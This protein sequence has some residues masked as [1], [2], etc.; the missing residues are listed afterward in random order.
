MK[1]VPLLLFL[2]SLCCCACQQEEASDGGEACSCPPIEEVGGREP[3]YAGQ[4]GAL[5]A[6][7]FASLEELKKVVGIEYESSLVRLVHCSN[8]L[9]VESVLEEGV[10]E[11]DIRNAQ[12]GG[13]WEKAQVGYGAPYAVA[14]RKDLG[15]I[16]IL[17]RRRAKFFGEG[18]VAFY[19]LAETAL[20]N[21]NTPDLAFR[22]PADTSE[23]GYINSFNHIT[24]QAFITS[25][26]SEE[27]ADFVADVHER[28]N[29]PELVSGEFT[30]EQLSD[31]E[32]NPTD[33]YVDMINNEWGQELGKRLRKQFGI[34]AETHWTPR[35]LADY[36]NELQAYYSWA[37]QIGFRSVQPQDEV[38]V[39]FADKINYVMAHELE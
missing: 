20:A 37:F 10:S 24:A 22:Y 19:D 18:D 29:M 13:A 32:N 12:R 35:L 7:R 27:L 38:V 25:F 31:P 6:T 28:K 39:R 23:K 34:S 11:K 21:I 16:S 2:L 1:T 4:Q 15:R 3:L 14:N 8:G 9:E 5:L 33:N 17:A 26:F 30:P 36:L